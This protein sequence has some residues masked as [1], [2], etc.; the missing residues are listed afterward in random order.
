MKVEHVLIKTLTLNLLLSSKVT[1]AIP[2]DITDCTIDHGICVCTGDCPAFTATWPYKTTVD[3][4]CIAAEN[5]DAV[6][7]ITGLRDGGMNGE[8]DVDDKEYTA[9]F[10]YCPTENNNSDGGSSGDEDN[11]SSNN[12]GYT[13]HHLSVFETVMVAVMMFRWLI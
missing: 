8:V 5:E 9:P 11:S 12:A 2:G 3:A 13:W 4:I 6:V 7:N 10:A 1:I